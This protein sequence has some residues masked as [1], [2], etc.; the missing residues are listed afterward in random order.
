MLWP[1]STTSLAAVMVVI[2][3]GVSLE[4]V[5]EIAIRE[6][7]M[8]QRGTPCGAVWTRRTGE[9]SGEPLQQ[10]RRKTLGHTMERLIGEHNVLTCRCSA[11]ICR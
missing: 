7:G 2:T 1:D 4:A 5:P 11:R 10:H 6:R 9:V 3:P 8:A